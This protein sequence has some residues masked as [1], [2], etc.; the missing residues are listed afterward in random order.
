MKKNN[1]KK[2]MRALPCK[3]VVAGVLFFIL[4]LITFT[5]GCQTL[6]ETGNLQDDRVDVSSNNSADSENTASDDTPDEN[7]AEDE[8]DGEDEDDSSG[9]DDLSGKDSGDE[10]E[11]QSDGA[12]GDLF[13][14]VYYA[15]SQVKYLVGESRKLSN[16]ESRY[17]E[18]LNELMKLPVDSSLI[19]LIPSTTV[20]NSVNVE[21]GTAKVDFSEN[22]VEDRL[23]S[24]T[25]DILLVYSVVNTLTEFSDVDAVSF[26]I[27]GKKLNVLGMLDLQNPCYRRSDLIK[28]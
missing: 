26:Y 3:L 10:T 11:E 19:R 15:D 25:E 23:T 4:S 2:K 17:A 6:D 24:E 16:D 1:I 18:A 22:F 27:D 12:E 5:I 21:K 20:I 28:G 13:I 8:T 9:E 7:N 14:N